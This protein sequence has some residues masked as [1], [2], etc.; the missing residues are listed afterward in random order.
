MLTGRR[1]KG[2]WAA[3]TQLIEGLPKGLDVLIEK[4]LQPDPSMRYQKAATARGDIGSMVL[5]ELIAGVQDRKKSGLS[6]NENSRVAFIDW[7]EAREK[8]KANQ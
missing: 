6:S 7:L 3:P 1:P 5:V 2:A 4:L 8:E